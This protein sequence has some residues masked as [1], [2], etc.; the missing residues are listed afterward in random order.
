MYK[1]KSINSFQCIL[2]FFCRS[3]RQFCIYSNT[4]SNW[5]GSI[6]LPCC[7]SFFYQEIKDENILQLFCLHF[8]QIKCFILINTKFG[9]YYWFPLVLILWNI[10]ILS[11]SI[12]SKCGTEEI[13]KP[14][15]NEAP[16]HENFKIT[17]FFHRKYLFRISKMSWK[18][19]L[20][21]QNWKLIWLKFSQQRQFCTAK[22]LPI[23]SQNSSS[24][25]VCKSVLDSFSKSHGSTS[26]VRD[27]RHKSEKSVFAL[28]KQKWTK[29]S[30]IVWL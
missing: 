11:C 16:F 4:I 24:S 18:E 29:V 10:W 14:T 28:C 7:N 2:C 19:Q 13:N 27:S 23:D 17:L 9:T 22:I 21:L 30:L 12:L 20:R 5:F 8:V 6:S 26:E 1:A 15:G 3:L 25:A